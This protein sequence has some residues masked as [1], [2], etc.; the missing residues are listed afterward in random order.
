MRT[1]FSLKI[2]VRFHEDF[3]KAF[4]VFEDDLYFNTASAGFL[5]QSPLV[6]QDHRK[7]E[8]FSSSQS[9][10][11]VRKLDFSSRPSIARCYVTNRFL[12]GAHRLR[13]PCTTSVF[14]YVE[15][16]AR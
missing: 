14:N 13:Q 11:Q 2:P 12:L 1:P 8:F 4:L 10:Q 3:Q 5:S 7:N 6:E 9:S 15:L 16:A